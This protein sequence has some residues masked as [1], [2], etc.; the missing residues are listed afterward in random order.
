[1]KT[2]TKSIPLEEYFEESRKAITAAFDGLSR[3]KEQLSRE[4][5]RL[6]ARAMNMMGISNHHVFRWLGQ[7][8]PT[9]AE[10]VANELP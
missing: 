3:D 2:T 10:V 7:R 9:F 1:M 6:I 8:R 4:Q 5:Y